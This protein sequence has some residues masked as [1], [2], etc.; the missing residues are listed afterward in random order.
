MTEER[1]SAQFPDTV[2]TPSIDLSRTTDAGKANANLNFVEGDP[3]AFHFQV[4]AENK[5]SIAIQADYTNIY[6]DEPVQLTIKKKWGDEEPG[7]GTVRFAI[8]RDGV[9]YGDI[10]LPITNGGTKSWETT[11]TGLPRHVTEGE[12]AGREIEWTVAEIGATYQKT[13]KNGNDGDP[14]VTEVTVETQYM[15]EHFSTTQR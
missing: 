1:E 10:S 13:E 4:T 3:F 5:D 15:T 7:N 14:A 2:L 8:Y 11:V 9:K 6:V 12:Q